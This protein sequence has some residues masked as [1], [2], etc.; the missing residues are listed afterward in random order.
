MKDL[1]YELFFPHPHPFFFV[2]PCWAKGCG[3]DGETFDWVFPVDDAM[4]VLDSVDFF[5]I[6]NL[7]FY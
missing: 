7:L 2:Y 1:F 5:F 6:M 4:C 3:V